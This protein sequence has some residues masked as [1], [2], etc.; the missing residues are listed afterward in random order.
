MEDLE[1]PGIFLGLVDLVS[2]IESAVKEHITSSGVF[3]A[4]W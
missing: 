2:S 4:S 1:N 3:N